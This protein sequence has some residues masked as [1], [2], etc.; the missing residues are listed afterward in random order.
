[1]KIIHIADIH[2]RGLSR[3]EEYILAFKDFFKK[4]KNLCPDIIYVG[5]DIV[6]NKTQGISPELI[7]YLSWWFNSL[8]SI[9]EVHVILGNHDGLILNKDRQD[10][11]TPIIK[12]INNPNIKLF[13]NSG[14]YPTGFD[15][16]NWCIFSCFDEEGWKNVHP[17]KGDINI[18]LYHGAARGA[19]TDT[20][21]QLDGEISSGMFKGY[22]YAL[23]GDIHK[24]QFL[25]D[26][27]TIAYSGS[28]IQQNYGEGIKKGFL[29]WD[30][31]GKN[32]FDVSFHE[33]KNVHQFH[34]IEW[35]GIQATIDTC[36]QHPRQ[37]RFRIRADNFISQSDSRKLRKI[38]KKTHNAKEVVYKIDSHFC[39]NDNVVD[40]NNTSLN[41]RNVD[42]HKT[43]LR[44]YYASQ[45]LESKEW[46]KLESFIECYL[47]KISNVERE[48]RN[49]KWTIEKI[50]F[51]NAFSYGDNNVINFN[52]LPGITGIFGKNAKG[53]S[54]IVGTIVYALFNTSDRGSIKNIHIINTRRNYCK[55]AIDIKLDGIPHR[56]VRQT[57]K[58]Q[59]RK[60]IWAPTTL[61]FYKLNMSGEI[62]ED[63]TDEQRRE[64]EKIIRSKIGNA[65]E[66]LMTSLASQGQMNMFIREK[67][68]AR[69]TILSNF[70]DLNIFDKLNEYAK[71]DS[72]TIRGKAN[73]LS[74]ENWQKKIDTCQT[75][76]DDYVKQKV[77]IGFEL[78]DEKKKLEVLNIELHKKDKPD[79]ISK[80]ELDNISEQVIKAQNEI[81]SLDSNIRAEKE[82]ILESEEKIYK[83]SS[84]LES[85]DVN[86]LRNKRKAKIE[87]EKNLAEFKGILKL[88]MKELQNIQKSVRKLAEVPCGDMFPSCMFIKDSHKNKKRIDRQTKKVT[89]LS[90]K[91]DDIS[92]NF[93]EYQHTNYEDLIEKYNKLLNRK[94]ELISSISEEKVKI[95]RYEQ[96]QKQNVRLS[97]E[98]SDDYCVLKEKINSEK[99]LCKK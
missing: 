3:H 44:N 14:I 77:N 49:S 68:A 46:E 79:F 48:S 45:N 41:L 5:G 96:H 21:W 65:E 64:T 32:D 26:K 59:T 36:L 7:Q 94:A 43:L 83:I 1:M 99:R 72:N 97:K 33:I 11:I 34:T 85:T 70:L 74:G 55:A 12:A 24:C 13:K 62:I 56:I 27:K 17:V 81:D 9:C 95:E 54:S 23:L 89:Y 78:E 25:N 20:D 92:S 42:I 61:K 66:F 30:I 10:A 73:S 40:D 4:T 6:H 8:A 16:I 90:V 93:K 28:T 53:K 87:I 67:A 51:D 63:L 57:R 84:F 39:S 37:S 86:E 18:A 69:K 80:E 82:K 15:G 58:K 71:R 75:K 35:Q 98:L 52:S 2:W 91:I 31:R 50:K 29:F 60:N 38:L 47:D 19:L 76:I 88:E 22:D